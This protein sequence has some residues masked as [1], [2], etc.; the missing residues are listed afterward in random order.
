MEY[1]SQLE[2][3]SVLEDFVLLEYFLFEGLHFMK[4]EANFQFVQVRVE[5]FMLVRDFLQKA[6]VLNYFPFMKCNR[7]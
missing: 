6:S 1:P 5:T 3:Y 4:W 2:D 7:N